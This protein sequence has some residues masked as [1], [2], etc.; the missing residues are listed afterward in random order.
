LEK[1]VKKTS[2][3]LAF[4]VLAG[5]AS[6]TPQLPEKRVNQDREI[7]KAL[8]A[9]EDGN[10]TKAYN[11]YSSLYKSSQ[12][13]AFY[14]KEIETL[15]REGKYNEVIKRAEEYYKKH[16]LER[17]IF[18]YE[19]LSFV[20][21][22]K[23]KKA[24]EL[25]KSR[26][27]KKDK[28]F[29]SMMSYLLI[30]QHRLKEA[31]YYLKSLYAMN[32]SKTTLLM[33]SDVLI[34]L[35]KYN[36]ALAYLRTHLDMYGCDYDVCMRLV[37]IYRGIYDDEN[38]FKI[39]EKLGAFD[40]K[41][42]IY[43]LNIL[44][45]NGEYK[46]AEKFIKEHNLSDSYLL[47]LYLQ[48]KDYR[49]AANIALKLYKET[50]DPRFLLKYCEFLYFD[51][52]TKEEIKDIAGKLEFLAKLYPSAYLYNFLGYILIDNGID[53]KKGLKYVKKAVELR[54]EN[55]EYV[56]S[57][58]WGYYK[59]GNCKEAWRIMQYIHSNDKEILKHKRLIKR[60]FYDSA[61]NHSTDKK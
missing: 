6:K 46:K 4:L 16:G 49:K 25:L 44:V 47:A 7:I 57:L 55:M 11:I 13:P 14:E 40:D 28:F 39:Y 29:Y 42:Y 38:L 31:V 33:L 61:K 22:K 34:R 37:R 60:C 23:Y 30:K 50:K 54:P 58:A 27:N 51:H 48:E 24:E 12:N 17:K 43:A 53:V 15:F 9:E 5:C 26:F 8:L 20:E 32:Q 3:V 52:P 21:L 36:E 41:Y 45:N 59:L 2:I 35:K 10:Y 56:D 19:I 1:K 18:E